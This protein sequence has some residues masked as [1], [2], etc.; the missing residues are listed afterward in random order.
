MPHDSLPLENAKGAGGRRMEEW[1]DGMEEEL[2]IPR[3]EN[4]EKNFYLTFRQKIRI[5]YRGAVSRVR[6]GLRTSPPRARSE[7]GEVRSENSVV[8]CSLLTPIPD[9]SPQRTQ[10]DKMISTLPTPNSPLSS[11]S[12]VSSVVNSSGYI[13]FPRLVLFE[14][15]I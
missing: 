4:C 10:S 8:P 2:L 13:L 15:R 6:T 11:V 7:D 1:R 9:Y 12:S 5:Y 14:K 3:P